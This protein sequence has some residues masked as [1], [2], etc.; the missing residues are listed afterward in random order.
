MVLE[1]VP[2]VGDK[3]VIQALA[4]FQLA[5]GVTLQEHVEPVF[6]VKLAL[7]DPD[8]KDCDADVRL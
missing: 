3:N 2:D 8:E 5:S 4:P 6:S 1:P 7:P